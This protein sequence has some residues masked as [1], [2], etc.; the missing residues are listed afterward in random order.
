[1]VPLILFEKYHTHARTN[2]FVYVL[3]QKIII[4]LFMCVTFGDTN[5]EK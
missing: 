2:K 1:M 5:L 4:N 3:K